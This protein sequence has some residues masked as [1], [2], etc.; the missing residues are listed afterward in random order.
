M[1][2]SNVQIACS[3]GTTG[4]AANRTGVIKV[5]DGASA[6]ISDVA[7]DGM[8]GVHACIW[9]QRTAMTAIAVNCHGIDDGIFS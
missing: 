9:H 6:T 8:N 1:T 2:V 4:E 5:Q 7:I 3:S